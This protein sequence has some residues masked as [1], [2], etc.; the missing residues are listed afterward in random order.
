MGK[1]FSRTLCS[2]EINLIGCI[3][4]LSIDVKNEISSSSILMDIEDHVDK[5]NLLVTKLNKIKDIGGEVSGGKNEKS[6]QKTMNNNLWTNT[7]KEFKGIYI[8][9]HLLKNEVDVYRVTNSFLA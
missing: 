7:G 1:H 3:N 9:V 6:L 5:M 2:F 4:F 8:C